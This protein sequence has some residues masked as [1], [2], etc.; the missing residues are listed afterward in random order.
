[1]TIIEITTGTDN[2][3]PICEIELIGYMRWAR[4]IAS[5]HEQVELPEGFSIVSNDVGFEIITDDNGNRYNLNVQM[6]QING[7]I[8]SV[9]LSDWSGRTHERIQLNVA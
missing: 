6:D 1:M 3:G 4:M 5:G 7:G 8:A 9:F 2:I